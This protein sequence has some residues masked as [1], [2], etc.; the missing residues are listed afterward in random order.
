MSARVAA[1]QQIPSDYAHIYISPHIDDAALSCGGAIA[2]H[3]A[4]GQRVLVM[5][6]CAAAPTADAPLSGYASWLHGRWGGSDAAMALRQGEDIAAMETLGAD[7]LWLPFLDA[8]YRMP[9]RYGSRDAIFGSLDP[10]DTLPAALA[11][12]LAIVAARAPEA[13]LYAPLGVGNHVDHQVAF[14]AA[15]QLASNGA[16]LAFYEEFPYAARHTNAVVD[17]LAALGG[18]FTPSTIPIEATLARKISALDAY[19]SQMDELFDGGAADLAPAV[20]AYAESLRPDEGTY[21][22]RLWLRA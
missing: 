15:W 11:D 10:A 2:R 5:T 18:P 22:E 3:V 12:T 20:T 21:G 14:N 1:P 7:Y 13:V 9:A 8:I 17:R 16:S 6:V 19:A 4:C